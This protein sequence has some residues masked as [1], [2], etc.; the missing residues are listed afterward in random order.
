MFDLDGVLVDSE[1]TWEEVRRAF[2]AEHGGRW[3]ADSQSRLLGMSTAEWARY[4]SEE[5]HVE[6]PAPRVAE[7]VIDEMARRYAARVPVLPGADGVLHRLAGRWQLGLASS[8]PRRLIDTVLATI[9]WQDLFETT[10]STEEVERGKPAPDVYETVAHRLGVPPAS[11]VAV[12]DSGNGM[13][14]AASAGLTLVAVPSRR[15]PP[16]AEALAHAAVVLDSL[17]ELTPD[18]IA[19]VGRRPSGHPGRRALVAV[20]DEHRAGRVFGHAG[21]DRAEQQPGEAAVATAAHHQ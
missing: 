5:M 19:R 16:S 14:A 21:A 9:G 17:A 11:C 12:E 18:V 13:L 20:H 10:V 2:V 7:A 8:S 3:P 4:I 1:P 15:Y 6:L